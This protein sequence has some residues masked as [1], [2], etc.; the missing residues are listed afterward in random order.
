MQLQSRN[1]YKIKQDIGVDYSRVMQRSI[2]YIA[3]CHV[4]NRKLTTSSKAKGM[5]QEDQIVLDFLNPGTLFDSFGPERYIKVVV[6]QPLAYE[7]HESS[8]HGPKPLG[9]ERVEHRDQW[10]TGSA[11]FFASRVYHLRIFSKSL[12]DYHIEDPRHERALHDLYNVLLSMLLYFLAFA[13]RVDV[14]NGELGATP[15]EWRAV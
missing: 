14:V 13:D 1:S 7:A 5:H 6:L 2:L 4:N 8:P 10:I 11:A 12:K 3:T 15:E 9:L